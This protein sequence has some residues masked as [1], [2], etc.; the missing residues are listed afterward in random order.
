MSEL[1]FPSELSQLHNYGVSLSFIFKS[2][3]EINAPPSKKD[4]LTGRRRIMRSI[5]SLVE[6]HGAVI[7]LRPQCACAPP[8]FLLSSPLLSSPSSSSSRSIRRCGSLRYLTARREVQ[9][10]AK[11]GRGPH[12]IHTGGGHIRGEPRRFGAAARPSFLLLAAAW[13]AP[14]PARTPR[15]AQPF[16]RRRTPDPL[17]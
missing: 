15:R 16:F 4:S 6:P 2:S 9:H 11:A 3:D 13:S 5:L 12:R 10:R 17:A 14:D 7:C 8:L 1:I